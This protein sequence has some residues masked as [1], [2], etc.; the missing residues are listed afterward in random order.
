MGRAE[1]SGSRDTAVGVI[2]MLRWC[3]LK[4]LPRFHEDESGPTAVEY[5]V[6]IA[7]IIVVCIGSVQSLSNATRSS[8]DASSSAIQSAL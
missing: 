2:N 6:I 5:A 3:T 4:L 8:L 7:L 1:S